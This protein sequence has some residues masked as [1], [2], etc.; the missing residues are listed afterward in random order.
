MRFYEANNIFIPKA[1]QIFAKA[2]TALESAFKGKAMFV[3][4]FASKH[5]HMKT[6]LCNIFKIKN[7]KT[8]IKIILEMPSSFSLISLIFLF[9]TH[10]TCS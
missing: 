4:L 5:N 1:K 10:C 3:K 9:R 7:S 2:L 6:R 8:F